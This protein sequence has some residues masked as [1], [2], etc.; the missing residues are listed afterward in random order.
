MTKLAA[1][2]DGATGEAVSTA[3]L[4]RMLKVVASR[5]QTAP[6]E[7]W[8][9]RELSGYGNEDDLPAYRGPFPATAMGVFVGPFQSMMKI[10]IPTVAFPE[11]MRGGFAF[12]LKFRQP[13]SELEPLAAAT[14]NLENPW[15]ADM[16]AYVNYKIESGEMTLVPMH[17]LQRA[18]KVVTPHEVRAVLDTVRTRVLNLAL[19]L[20]R[21][22]PQAGEPNAPAVDPDRVQYVVTNNIYGDGNATAVG[23]PGAVQGTSVVKQGDL[24][25]LLRAASAAGLPAPEVDELRSAVEA[26]AAAGS[27]DKPGSQVN[28]YMGKLALGA[29]GSATGGTVAALIR[30]FFGF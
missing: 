17:G 28:E 25:S 9:D 1:I 29:A 3:S 18:Y 14:L 13:V 6:L 4:L 7:D 5:L 12:T 27:P 30:A 11:H 2:I 24:E 26:D 23:S 8:V 19:E 21:I 10:A 20:E 16:V 15:D 22:A